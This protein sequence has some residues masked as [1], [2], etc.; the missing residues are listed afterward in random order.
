MN[1][2]SNYKRQS[3]NLKTRWNNKNKY[4]SSINKKNKER[5]EV[6]VKKYKDYSELKQSFKNTLVR[7]ISIDFRFPNTRNA[8]IYKRSI[9]IEECPMFEQRNI[10]YYDSNF[11]LFKNKSVSKLVRTSSAG[12]ISTKQNKI[13]NPEHNII[14]TIKR[15]KTLD[16][17]TSQETEN[18]NDRR[19]PKQVEKEIYELEVI[20]QVI[21]GGTGEDKNNNENNKAIEGKNIIKYE[22][23]F[24]DGK[25]GEIEQR[26]IENEKDKKNNLLNTVNV[27]IEKENG[28][29]ELIIVEISKTEKPK[30]KFAKIRSL[31][32]RHLLSDKHKG[33]EF[34]S[35]IENEYLKDL[36]SKNFND[37]KAM[38]NENSP[39]IF[40]SSSFK[41]CNSLDLKNEKASEI[42]I[43]KIANRKRLFTSK[44]N[45]KKKSESAMNIKPLNHRIKKEK[46]K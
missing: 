13:N 23:E 9:P 27:E 36:L 17:S 25:W 8:Y 33:E 22:K 20:N 11:R 31:E 37:K 43:N 42:F 3:Q 21:F 4:Y 35:P 24:D 5:K 26:I 7:N 39:K 40:I 15:I 45:K 19:K 28:D 32:E 46:N 10:F 16:D 12:N 29:K 38:E 34:Y 2:F 1:L 30:K 14:T 18:E 41:N 6:L 44:Y